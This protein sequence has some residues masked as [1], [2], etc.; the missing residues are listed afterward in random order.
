M[1]VWGDGTNTWTYS[2]REEY[3]EQVKKNPFAYLMDWTNNTWSFAKF[4]FGNESTDDVHAPGVP[5][6]R[7]FS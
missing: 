5:G 7:F 2:E 4:F 3:E 1:K 6:K